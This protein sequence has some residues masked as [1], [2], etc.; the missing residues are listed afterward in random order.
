MRSDPGRLGAHFIGLPV[1]FLRSD[2]LADLDPDVWDYPD[3][4]NDP[5]PESD[6]LKSLGEHILDW[7]WQKPDTA[8][9]TKSDFAVLRAQATIPHEIRHFH[10][11][12]VTPGL[13][14]RFVMETQRVHIA[15]KILAGMSGRG[16]GQIDPAHLTREESGLI[17]FH[18]NRT[19]EFEAAYAERMRPKPISGLGITADISDL[20]EADAIVAELFRVSAIEGPRALNAYWKELKTSLPIKYTQLLEYAV[21]EGRNFTGDLER[22]QRALITALL[23]PGNP[24]DTFNAI[25]SAP[26]RSSDPGRYRRALSIAIQEPPI[27]HPIFQLRPYPDEAFVHV[28]EVYSMRLQVLELHARTDLTSLAYDEHL[29]EFPIPPTCF[30]ADDLMYSAK[31]LPFVRKA[32]LRRKYGGVFSLYNRRDMTRRTTVSAGLIPTPGYD[33]ALALNRVESMLSFRYISQYLF[34]DRITYAQDIDAAY[35]A[36]AKSVL[37]LDMVDPARVV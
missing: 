22:F 1:I 5:V 8:S 18:R 11:A 37:G 28:T 9:K 17:R 2:V 25:N 33:S 14:E 32:D 12:L 30:F 21:P 16:A 24:I 19:A 6:L 35:Q 36:T 23:S 34:G 27:G 13:F 3:R 26:E 10:D 7:V 15:A 29:K 31:V 4:G 20:L